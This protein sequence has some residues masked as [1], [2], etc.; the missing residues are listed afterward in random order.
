[1]HFSSEVEVGRF[2]FILS[3]FGF[4]NEGINTDLLK[5][6]NSDTNDN[7]KENTCFTIT[8]SHTNHKNTHKIVVKGHNTIQISLKISSMI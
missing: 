7:Q 5:Q 1:M 6:N 2:S 8:F 3:C 4:P